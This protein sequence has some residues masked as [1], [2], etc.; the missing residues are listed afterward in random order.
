M[1]PFHFASLFLFSSILFAGCAGASGRASTQ[2]S[3]PVEAVGHTAQGGAS[4]SALVDGKPISGTTTGGVAH[5]S[6]NEDATKDGLSFEVG[7][8]GN[9]PGFQFL[10]NQSGTT[11]LRGR[12]IRT[13]CN[14]RSPDKSLYIVDSAT[15]TIN[16]G[17]RTSGTFSGRWK[18]AHYGN[19]PANAPE[20]V[21]ITEGKFD[22]P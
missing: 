8:S 4:W 3:T 11:Q 12:N 21:Q 10:V 15:V 9:N 19:T 6:L 13:V 18:N 17:A 5:T 14:Y 7:Y 22:L 20:T 2:D 1:K 16:P